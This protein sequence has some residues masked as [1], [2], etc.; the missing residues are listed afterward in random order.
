MF[1]DW[2]RDN[3]QLI[4]WVGIVSIVLFF[5]SLFL[6]RYVILR[7]P[8]DYFINVS[9]ISKSNSKSVIQKVKIFKKQKNVQKLLRPQTF[10]FGRAGITRLGFR[11]F[12]KPVSETS[13]NQQEVFFKPELVFFSKSGFG[14]RFLVFFQNPSRGL[15]SPT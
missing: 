1:S 12:R 6:L 11:W 9:S 4:Q 10:H 8:E 7:L 3:D 5:L 15:H 2:I 13:K 14:N